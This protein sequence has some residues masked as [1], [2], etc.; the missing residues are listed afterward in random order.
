MHIQNK[1]VTWLVAQSCLQKPCGQDFDLQ[2]KES[3]KADG[4]SPKCRRYSV[5]R[6]FSIGDSSSCYICMSANVYMELGESC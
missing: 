6:P 1:S 2:E 5:K 4:C 3:L